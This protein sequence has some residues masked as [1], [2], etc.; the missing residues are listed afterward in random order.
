MTKKSSFYWAAALPSA[1][2]L[3]AASFSVAHA[4]D[5]KEAIQVAVQTNP[6]ISEATQ[7]MQAIEFERKQAQGQY[8]PR[9]NLE[10]SAGARELQN[11]TRRELGIATKGLYP[12]EVDLT[13]QQS[14]FDFG[15]RR[16]ELERQA[17]RTDG[18]A[19][20]VLERSEFI[21][22]ETAREYINYLL[23]QRI[24]ATAQANIAY[25]QKM[26]DDLASGVNKGATSVADQQQAQ[27][28]LESARARLAQAQEDLQ[29]AAIAFQTRTGLTLDSAT[30]PP[31]F[32]ANTPKTEDEAIG[33]A[34]TNNPRV[35]IAQA[36]VDAS[37]AMIKSAKANMAPNISVEGTGRYGSDI[38]GFEGHTNDIMGRVVFRWTLY[39]GGINEANVQEQIRRAS[40][41]RY[42]LHQVVREVED[43][44][45]TS[46]N[47]L[48]SQKAVLAS[49][50][51]QT[52]VSNDLM[53]SYTDQFKVGRRSLLDLLDNQNTLYSA[54]VAME[55]ARYAEL[56]AQ[57]R[58]LAAT[59]H[60]LD[61]F[62]VD[63][64]AAA[65]TEAR[66]QF[67]VP[68]TPPAELQPRHHVD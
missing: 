49:L 38:D 32:A 24:V 57:Y 35:K 34:R 68:A 43:D 59:G 48:N 26:T 63:R 42:A 27:E 55:T 33:E 21:A 46:W 20:R 45:R 23:Q 8:L 37:E 54:T 19:K 66:Q 40:Q 12:A 16:A 67:G 44:T 2:L 18:A 28:R 25:H 3:T 64:P 6:Q 7:D 30:A 61:A 1:V 31:D 10:A 51:A 50:E 22:L 41:S 5:L 58:V 36:D 15:T 53:G 62:G 29:A 60:L 52:K 47:R 65:K 11:P 39:A 13:V 14:V 56:F 17:A 9:V 4:L